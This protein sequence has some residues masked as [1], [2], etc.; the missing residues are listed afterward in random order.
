VPVIVQPRGC[1]GYTTVGDVV[2][3][4]L[5][6]ILVE[7]GDSPLEPDEYQDAMAVMNDYLASLEAE[8]LKLGYARACNVSDIVTVPDGAMRGLCAN[9][10]LELAPQFGGKVSATL[11]K[12]ATDGMRA[13]RKYGVNIGQALY[14][15]NFPMGAGNCGYDVGSNSPHCTMTIFGNQRETVIE[16]AGGAEKVQGVW[17]IGAFSVLT[18]DVSGR[19]TNKGPK[20][21][22]NISAELAFVS[23]EDIFEAVIGIVRNAQFAMYTTAALSAT[24]SAVILEGTVEL[25]TNQFIDLVVT[26]VYTTSSITLTDGFMRIW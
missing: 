4:A 23:E 17:S 8:G 25:D 13:L 14:P 12:Q 16:T 26:D 9:L 20:Q 11:V 10:A 22:F 19:I 1:F 24:P 6:L 5:K 21:T 18:P 7:A 3:R 15:V 2:S